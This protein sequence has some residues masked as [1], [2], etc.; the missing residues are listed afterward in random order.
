MYGASHNMKAVGL[1][2]I[3]EVKHAPLVKLLRGMFPGY[4]ED[5]AGAFYRP[6]GKVDVVAGMASRSLHCRDGYEAGDLRMTKSV[7]AL[8]GLLIGQAP[9]RGRKKKMI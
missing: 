2:H 4:K 1:E 8:G 5:V 6:H 7:F 9:A 3:T